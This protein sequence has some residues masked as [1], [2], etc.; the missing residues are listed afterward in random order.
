[1]ANEITKHEDKRIAN[2]PYY[3]ENK[4][5]TKINF[6]LCNAEYREEV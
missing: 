5:I 3:F 4:K 6:K 2:K 1:M